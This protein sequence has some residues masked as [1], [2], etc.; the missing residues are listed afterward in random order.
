MD[1]VHFH[2]ILIQIPMPL[3]W[4]QN[5]VAGTFISY[6][7]RD[8]NSF[9][10]WITGQMRKIG[11]IVWVCACLLSAHISCCMESIRLTNSP[12]LSTGRYG[13]A[14]THI[15]QQQR[16]CEVERP[17]ASFN[18]TWI[19]SRQPRSHNES[20]TLKTDELYC[21]LIK[22]WTKVPLLATVL[23]VRCVYWIPNDELFCI[24]NR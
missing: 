15:A 4:K 21:I 5:A 8:L 3:N 20:Q 12:W 7:R 24:S 11:G 6:N 17:S 13:S 23:C 22:R 9:S 2:L 19:W 16:K 18:V 14:L 1:R 10:K